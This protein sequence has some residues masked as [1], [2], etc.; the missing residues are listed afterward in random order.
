MK[1]LDEQLQVFV[2][3]LG[4]KG[5][6]QELF[7]SYTLIKLLGSDAAH[8]EGKEKTCTCFR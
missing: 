7:A 1:I 3:Y 6:I 4:S 8:S 2:P 5:K